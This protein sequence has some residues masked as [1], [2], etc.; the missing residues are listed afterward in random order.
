METRNNGRRDEQ[1]YD[2]VDAHNEED[3]PLAIDLLADAEEKR[4]R[5]EGYLTIIGGILLLMFNG[6]FFLWANISVY[7]LSYF[8]IH[9]KTINQ[10]AIFYIDFLLVLLN[11]T[12]Y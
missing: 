11:V 7:V 1:Y 9:D 10:N 8:Y 12:G 2:Q 4:L 5:R 3:R 6:C